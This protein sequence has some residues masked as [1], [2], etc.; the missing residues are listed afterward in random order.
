MMRAPIADGG[1]SRMKGMPAPRVTASQMIR[2]HAPK[3]AGIKQAQKK[4]L[5][6][7]GWFDGGQH[8]DAA[9]CKQPAGKQQG[10]EGDHRPQRDRQLEHRQLKPC[11]RNWRQG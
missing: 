1:G 5:R 4:S 6:P 3:M 7:L 2:I 8:A 10:V 9:P 11:Q